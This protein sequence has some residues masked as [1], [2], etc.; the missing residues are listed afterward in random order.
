MQSV[1]DSVLRRKKS[2]K[3]IVQMLLVVMVV[4][5]LATCA[6][7]RDTAGAILHGQGVLWKIEKKDLP[8]SYI[9]GTMHVSDE[10]VTQLPA[11]VEQAFI[12]SRHFV[13]E[14]LLTPRAMD[15]I[16]QASYFQDG[17]SLKQV[18][19]ADDF[20]RLSLLLHDHFQLPEQVFNAL[21]PWAVLILLSTQSQD[22]VSDQV[23]DRVLYQRAKTRGM[24]MHGLE[25][26]QQQLAVMGGLAIDEQVWLLNQAVARFPQLAANLQRM[27]TLYLQRDVAGVM[28]LQQQQMDAESDIDDRF[29]YRLLDQR[30]AVMARQIDVLLQQGSLFIAI[31]ALH[32]PGESGV[33]HLLER[34]G[35]TISVVY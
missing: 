13:M 32:L 34:Q 18:M 30:N 23:L 14:M 2:M 31:G 3:E 22:V 27:T 1:S 12:H 6:N 21:Q 17:H 16:T 11:E 24:D 19:Q 15:I 4:S 33:L 5:Q 7:I 29:L 9:F 20:Q 26:A 28:T 25:T 35:Y 10:R 8:P